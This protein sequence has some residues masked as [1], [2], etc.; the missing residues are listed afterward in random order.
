MTAPPVRLAR[1]GA[2]AHLTLDRA[3]A[4]NALDLATAQALHAAA[5]HIAAEAGDVGAVLVT[6]VGKNFCVGGD[7]GEFARAEEPTGYVHAVAREVHAA[8]RI[9]TELPAPVVTA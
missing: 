1:A 7:L 3:A 4:G 5:R 8:L 6:A 9:L 2:L